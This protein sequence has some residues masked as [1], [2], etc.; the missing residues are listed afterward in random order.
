MTQLT[1]LQ[2]QS[3][4]N[5]LLYY[6]GFTSVLKNALFLSENYSELLLKQNLCK[7]LQTLSALTNISFN[8]LSDNIHAILEID[9]SEKKDTEVFWIKTKVQSNCIF[10]PARVFNSEIDFVLDTGCS[11]SMINYTWFEKSGFLNNESVKHLEP[12]K[13]YTA[14]GRFKTCLAV[15]GIDFT[16]CGKSFKENTFLLSNGPFLLGNDILGAFK[17]FEIN[18][19]EQKIKFT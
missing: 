11:I 13:V 15:K 18:N 6:A 14:D 10:V 16:F 12:Q 3:C 7:H 1:P 8:D 19:A 9:N 4:K 2:I 17:G 5:A